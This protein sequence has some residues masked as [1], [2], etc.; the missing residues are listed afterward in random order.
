MY[1]FL[2]TSAILNGALKQY[3]TN[4]CIS[5]LAVTELEN[6]KT[7]YNKDEHIKYLAREAVRE[8]ISSNNIEY[9][10]VS[11]KQINKLLKKY[12]FLTDINDHRLL[13]EASAL[14]EESN[15]EIEFITSDGAQFLFADQIPNIQAVFLFD[16]ETGYIHFCVDIYEK[17]QGPK[18]QEKYVFD[19]PSCDY[20]RVQYRKHGE[21]IVITYI[22]K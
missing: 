7:S 4:I 6:I 16:K 14:A 22:G 17:G 13:C 12:N 21:E 1:H 19:W 15:E 3:Q 2:D 20:S 9:S 11:Q 10:M 18:D 8:I 5:P